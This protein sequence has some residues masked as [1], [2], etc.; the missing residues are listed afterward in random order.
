VVALVA[1]VGVRSTLGT[2]VVA[3]VLIALMVFSNALMTRH[4]VKVDETA[5][6]VSGELLKSG[7]TLE[8]LDGGWGWFCYYHLHPG[9]PDTQGYR[10][11]YYELRDHARYS[12]GSRA[13]AL[14]EIAVR[15]VE[16]PAT[17]V[18]PSTRVFALDRMPASPSV[19]PHG[20]SD[21]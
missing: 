6:Q 17:L 12:V 2:T 3:G 19:P 9:L 7:V 15:A 20:G 1:I 18:G 16:V 11:R 21:R 5:W 4:A 13:P 10:A 14:G 8:Q